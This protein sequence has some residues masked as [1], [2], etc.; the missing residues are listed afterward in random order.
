MTDIP[1][2]LEERG[3]SYGNYFEQTKII[4][5]FRRV[6]NKVLQDKRIFLETDQEDALLMIIVKI[7]RILNGNPDHI[8]N[9]ADIAGYATLVASRL[10]KDTL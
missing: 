5:D 2:T 7:S 1:K 3:E 8:D 9:W 6:L 10:E 4:A